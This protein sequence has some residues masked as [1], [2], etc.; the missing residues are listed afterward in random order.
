VHIL[1]ARFNYTL[2]EAE[3]R[4][5][6]DQLAPNFAD[7]PGCFE[8]TWILDAASSTAGGVYKFRDE[9]SLRA[10]LASPLWKGV[11]STPQFTNLTTQAFSTIPRATEI[12]HGMP[13][14]AVAR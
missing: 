8:K 10:Y 6:A 1:I 3:L 12:T 4:A 5:T 13:G 7:I 2:T 11:E 9:A 14:A